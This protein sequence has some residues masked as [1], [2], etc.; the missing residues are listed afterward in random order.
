MH[1]SERINRL[2]NIHKRIQQGETGTPDEFA[3]LF[4]LSRRQLYNI[5]D[6]LTG[7]GANI[8]Y[9]RTKHTYSYTNEFDI[10][11]QTLHFLSIKDENNIL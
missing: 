4:H 5:R 9:S 3:K 7:Y 1:F 2:Y 11:M 10:S 6:E 8:K